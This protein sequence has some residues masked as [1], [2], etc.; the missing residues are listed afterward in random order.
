MTF[1]PTVY[2]AV[3]IGG[4][5][6]GVAAAI[7]AYRRRSSP[8]GVWLLL[9]VL[10][11][12]WWCFFD[13]MESSAVGVSAHVFWIQLS[14]LGSMTVCTFLMLFAFEYT[15][16]RR[17]SAWAIGAL[18]VV[19]AIGV[20]AAATN[21]MHHLV[22]SGFTPVPGGMNLLVYSHGWVYWVVALYNFGAAA[23]ATVTLIGF[24]L[25]AEQT[26]FLQ[27]AAIIIAVAVP[28]V[29]GIIYD[30]APGALPGVDPSVTLALSGALLTVSLVQFRLLDLAPVA[31]DKLIERMGDGLLVLDRESRVL[32]SNPAAGQ[33]I[34]TTGERWIGEDVRAALA[35][36]PEAA[37]YLSEAAHGDSDTTIVSPAG[38]S[39]NVSVVPLE[40]A[41]AQRS[42]SMVMLRDI[43]D[44]VDTEAA[45]HAANVDL[46]LRI[47]EI[48]ELQEELREQA[49]RDPLTGLYNRRYL[50]EMLAREL[51]RA[52]REDYP[53]SIVM[54]DVDRFKD[55]NDAHGHA[56]GDQVL[57]FLG[58]QFR[59]EIRAGDIA[60]RYGG[61]EF[62]LVLP[63]ASAETAFARAEEW[64]VGIEESSVYWMEW[65][66]STTLS[67]GVA[68]FPTHGS[69]PDEIMMAADHALY[70]AKSEGRDRTIL[71]T[72]VEPLADR[73]ETGS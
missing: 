4:A 1:Q 63:N 3:Y 71:A 59:A 57:R 49:I 69:T 7:L 54:V 18:F 32:D 35:A 40:D 15:G 14:Y 51:G 48:E 2:T 33:I 29:A 30:F 16:R 21:G 38:R 43:T 73:R 8:G 9:M 72:A 28:W 55:V 53:V 5:G 39:I 26:Y 37:E 52:Q 13:A 61:D 20:V 22:W 19:P 34:G 10:A 45:L 36:W 64:R 27:S 23:I 24:A 44:Q 41:R 25:R 70:E 58:A 65:S 66:E 6:V 11:A 62:L 68:A 42:G 17:L 12:T 46:D 31:R 67:A 60:C 50:S 47:E 56:A